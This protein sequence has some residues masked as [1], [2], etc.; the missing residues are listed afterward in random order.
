METTSSFI[1]TLKKI[2][3]VLAKVE[4]CVLMVCFS[5]IAVALLMQIIFRYALNSPLIWTEELSR[6]L[7]VWITFLGINYAL[8]RNK[9]I[10]MEY[11]FNMMPNMVQRLVVIATQI[12]ILYFMVCLY[13]PTLSFVKMQMNIA[14]SAMQMNMGL[15]YLSLPIGFFI[16]SLSLLLSTLDTLRELGQSLKRG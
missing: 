15:V 8:R 5:T 4:E 1:S 6:Y 10:R 16:S 3:S 12:M 14:S 9:H 7:L 11:F 2:G 13:G